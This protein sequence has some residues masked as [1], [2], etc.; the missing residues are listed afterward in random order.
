[1]TTNDLHRKEN[2]KVDH[3]AFGGEITL[4]DFDTTSPNK[5]RINNQID[6]DKFKDQ[7]MQKK[8]MNYI[9]NHYTLEELREMKLVSNTNGRPTS[10]LTDEKW[11]K[12]FRLRKLFITPHNKSVRKLS[13]KYS[14]ESGMWNEETMGTYYGCTSWQSYC[15]Y[16]NDVLDNIRMGQTDY[17][18]FI[19]Q[20][21]ELARFHYNTLRTRYRD[22]YWEVWLDR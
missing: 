12:E 13:G 10:T 3:S 16:I 6:A 21:M 8:G 2:Y 20:I 5:R 7:V 1:M 15:S 17:C 14:K 9:M 18:Y 11:Q 4:E 19:Y 22:G